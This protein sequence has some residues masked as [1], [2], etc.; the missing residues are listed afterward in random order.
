LATTVE[1]CIIIDKKGNPIQQFSRLEGLQN[2]NVLSVFPDKNKNLWLGLDHGID[3]IAYNS[4]IK[5]IFPDA[6]NEGAGYSAIIFNKQLYIATT[7]GL[8]RAPLYEMKDMSFVKGSFKPVENT[9]GQVWNLS[10]VNGKLL[11]GHHEG[12]REVKG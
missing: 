12:F 4:A 7:N 11:I 3:F 6:V 2:N 1:G 8:Y 5:H 9:S 10:E